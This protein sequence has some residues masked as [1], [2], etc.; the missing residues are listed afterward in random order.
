[1]YG[2]AVYAVLATVVAA[3][4]FLF[5]EW[6]REPGTPAPDRPG[7]T[8][9]AAGLVWPVLVIGILQ[10]LAVAA[11]ESRLRVTTNPIVRSREDARP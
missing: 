3:A 2:I 11:V 7:L 10:C 4:A 6:I 1:M 5:S 9:L 8:A